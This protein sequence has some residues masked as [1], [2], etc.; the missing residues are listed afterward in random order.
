MSI[1]RSSNQPPATSHRRLR[2]GLNPWIATPAIGLGL[3]VAW[4]GWLVTDVS[5]R[6]DQAPGGPGCPGWSAV[7]ALVSFLGT[8]IGMAIVL[9]LAARSIAEY[10]ESKEDVRS[11]N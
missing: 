10:R 2:W 7:I 5:C 9:A 3:L 1:H 11:E 6:A 8:T 4:L